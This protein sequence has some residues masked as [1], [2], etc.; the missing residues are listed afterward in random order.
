VNGVPEGTVAGT[1]GS[2]TNAAPLTIGAQK[3]GGAYQNFWNGQLDD[4]RIWKRALSAGDVMR[5][6][7]EPWAPWFRP[8]GARG[9]QALSWL[10][11]AHGSPQIEWYRHRPFAA[12]GD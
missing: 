8:F 3:S 1:A 2:I 12:I 10:D 4:L 9:I 6:Y 11:F 7:T 5:L